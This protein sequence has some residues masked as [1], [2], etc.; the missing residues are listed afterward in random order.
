ME[1]EMGHQPS[2]VGTR[3][4]LETAGRALPRG[5]CPASTLLS[6]SW[7]PELREETTVV[8][9]HPLVLGCAGGHARGATPDVL[10]AGLLADVHSPHVF[11]PAP[12]VPAAGQVGH[13][14]PSHRVEPTDTQKVGAQG[15]STQV[16]TRVP[17]WPRGTEALSLERVVGP[18]GASVS[19]TC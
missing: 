13:V 18:P 2:T 10:Q 14:G 15:P 11:L 1:M 19:L 16:H 3:G 6:D 8:L 12:C 5:V 7:P 9:S 17:S 4:A